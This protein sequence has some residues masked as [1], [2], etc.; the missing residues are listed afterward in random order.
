[1]SARPKFEY[2]RSP[3]LLEACRRLACQHCG[4]RDGTVCAAH[5]NWAC[6]GKGRGIKASDVYVAAMCHK[7]HGCLDEGGAW[8][9]A[10]KRLFWW[11][12]HQLTVL[13]LVRLG[14]WPAKVREPDVSAPPAGFLLQEEP[15]P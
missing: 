6:H 9:A 1:M 2:V 13:H 15:A 3:K 7:C 4:R 14:L 8:S 10:H 12:A 11:L 5:S